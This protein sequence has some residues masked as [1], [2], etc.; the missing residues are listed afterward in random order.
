[1]CDFAFQHAAQRSTVCGVADCG[2]LS[3][4]T[5][6]KL[7][8]V[9]NLQLPTKP[10]MTYTDCYQLG[11]NFSVIELLHFQFSTDLILFF[12]SAKK[13]LKT[14]KLFCNFWSAR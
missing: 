10:A 12:G 6:M 4:Q 7:M 11:F 14:A 9:V 2:L 13:A 3:C 5:E 1:M 8:R